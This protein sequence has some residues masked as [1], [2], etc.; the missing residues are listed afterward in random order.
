MLTFD[1]AS[2]WELPDRGLRPHRLRRRPRRVRRDAHP[3]AAADSRAGSAGR[4]PA[5]GAEGRRHR[6]HD[7][8]RRRRV[9]ERRGDR[10]LCRN[11]AEGTDG[12]TG[13]ICTEIAPGRWWG[14]LCVVLSRRLRMRTVDIDEARQDLARLV[15]S[16]AGGEGFIIAK[17]GKPLVKIVPLDAPPARKVKRGSA[18][19]RGKSRFRMISTRCPRTRSRRSFTATNETV[20]RH[21]PAAVGGGA[22]NPALIAGATAD[23]RPGQ[24]IVVQRGKHLGDRDQAGA[25]AR[26]FPDNPRLLRRSLLDHEY[27]EFTIT[28]EHAAAIANLPPLHRDPFDRMLVAQSIVEGVILLTADPVV[29]QYPAPVQKVWRKA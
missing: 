4:R 29:A 8:Q 10:R 11:G 23:Y 15:D 22:I 18:S 5:P 26:R 3:A 17:E 7:R 21:P 14:H 19:S 24:R 16:A 27:R 20:A 9:R 1:N 6:R 28:G 13:L 25:G 2:A 12:G